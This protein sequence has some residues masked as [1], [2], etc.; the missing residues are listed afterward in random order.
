M[1]FEPTSSLVRVGHDTLQ[2]FLTM[3]KNLTT[4][5]LLLIALAAV[6]LVIAAFS[7]YLLQ[8]P[9]APLPFVPLPAT[10]TPTPISIAADESTV[11]NTPTPTRRISYTPLFAFATPSIGT[12]SA[13]TTQLITPTLGTPSAP[14][15]QL[16]TPGQSTD[17]PVSPYP[18]PPQ[19][20]PSNMPVITNTP[21]STTPA[22][23][24][25]S[26]SPTSGASPTVTR[27]LA[28]GEISITGRMVQNGTPIPNVVVTFADDV[29]PRQ[30]TTNAGGHYSFVTLAPGANFIL[31]FKQSDN[32]GLTPATDIASLARIEGTLPTN[33]NPID[34]PDME[35]SVNLSGMIFQLISP[36]DGAT[37]SASVVSASNPLQFSWSLYSQGGSYS[38][39]IGPN[40]ADQP[41]WVSGQLAATSTMWNGT[42]TDGTHIAAGNYWWRVAVTKSLGNYVAMIYTQQ[43]DLTFSQ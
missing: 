6:L 10:G 11:Q 3:I 22:S 13:P 30:S 25:V 14:P 26:P 35:I 4:N 36:N 17:T 9:T 8:N 18:N 7:F 39:E 37:Y 27:T 2:L 41:T 43:F 23:G 20:S 12:P 1:H 21:P 16:I 34:F 19:A 32:P 28:A 33:T 15:T 42:L 5:Q 29:A 31:T 24:T 40:G 38:V